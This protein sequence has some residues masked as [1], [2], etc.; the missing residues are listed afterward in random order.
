[1]KP[2]TLHYETVTPLLLAVLREVMA[3][4]LFDPFRLVGG[5]ALSLQCGHRISDDIDLFADAVYG[6]LDFKAMQEWLYARFP[7]CTGDCNE[8]VGVGTS[9]IVGSDRNH[10]V[11]VDLF[12]TD[13]FIKPVVQVDDIRL[14]DL[15]DIVAMKLEVVATGGRKKDF[16]DLHELHSRYTLSQM[17]TW[18]EERNPYTA[19]RAKTITRLTDF[20]RADADVDPCCLKNKVWPL[21]KLDM[22][23]WVQAELG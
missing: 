6:T 17:L 11:K 20:A 2:E 5:T 18:Y 12:Y 4:P 10:N 21:I 16:W 13:P 7:Y 3:C 22:V 15:A 19:D 8:S 9:Y 23:D 14:T 1:M